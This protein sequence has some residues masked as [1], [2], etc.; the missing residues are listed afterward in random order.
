M[1]KK[2]LSVLGAGILILGFTV[3]GCEFVT[4]SKSIDGFSGPARSSGIK[5]EELTAI[6]LAGQIEGLEG[7]RL[8]TRYWTIKPGGV[9]PLHSHVDRPA[10]IYVVQ[11]SIYEYRSDQ[12]EPVLHEAGGISIEANVNHWWKNT[13][14]EVCILVATDIVNDAS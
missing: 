5:A 13:S 4:N 11:G 10:T 14:D 8:R 7:R 2:K 6:D 9:V 1:S 3:G 12:A